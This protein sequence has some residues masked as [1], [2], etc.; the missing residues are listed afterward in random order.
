MGTYQ[1]VNLESHYNFLDFSDI[2]TRKILYATPTNELNVNNSICSSFNYDQNLYELVLLNNIPFAFPKRYEAVICEGQEIALIPSRCSEIHILGNSFAEE[3]I[4]RIELS[5]TDG[6]CEQ[7][8]VSFCLYIN[9][10]FRNYSLTK[11]NK[12]MINIISDGNPNGHI[13]H[14]SSL[15]KNSDLMLKSVKLPNNMFVNIFAI[16]LK[17]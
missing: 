10:S 3:S 14:S 5:F 6:S 1:Q 11:V 9:N 4:D 15:I 17:V 16:S 2:H 8:K 13:Y 7:V 12:E